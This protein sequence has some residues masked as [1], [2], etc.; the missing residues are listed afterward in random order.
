MK[1]KSLSTIV[2]AIGMSA[3]GAAQAFTTDIPGATRT[4]TL[5]S[6]A[7]FQGADDNVDTL[8]AYGDGNITGNVSNGN[9]PSGW[10]VLVDG[11]ESG[12]DTSIF[13]VTGLSN[14]TGTFNLSSNIWA[15]MPRIAIGFK[16]GNNKS[17]DW[18][19]IELEKY[20]QSGVWSNVPVQGATLSHYMIY[21]REDGVN[22]S[23]VPVPA[24]AWMLGSGLIG[25]VGLGRRNK[26]AV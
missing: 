17:P 9:I 2:L 21:G 18:V 20:A 22:P 14:G 24:A 26:R 7:F 11:S 16:V 19:I 3:T 10:S 25:L 13:Q 12:F 23:E 6:T 8:V 5:D 4:F 1:L 15:S